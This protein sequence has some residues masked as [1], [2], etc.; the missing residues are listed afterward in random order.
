MEHLHGDPGFIAL[1]PS[2][3]VIVIVIDVCFIGSV[4]DAP[5]SDAGR[6]IVKWKAPTMRRLLRCTTS[7]VRTHWRWSNGATL[8]K[9]HWE[10]E[11][12]LPAAIAT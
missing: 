8:R 7:V 11:G 9:T 5:S 6:V 2:H 3:A 10:M 1:A 4:C 12:I